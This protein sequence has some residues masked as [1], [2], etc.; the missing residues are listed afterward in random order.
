[1]SEATEQRH[2]AALLWDYIASETGLSRHLCKQV[3]F[4]MLFGSYVIDTAIRYGLTVDEIVD[5][6]MAFDEYTYEHK[7]ENKRPA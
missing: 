2:D 5:I 4:Q 1:M 6:R 3:I 7:T